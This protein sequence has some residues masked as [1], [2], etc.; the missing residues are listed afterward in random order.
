MKRNQLPRLTLTY[1][2]LIFL[3]IGCDAPVNEETE[4]LKAEN[5]KVEAN[6]EMYSQ[7]WDDILNKGQ[8]DLFNEA[9][10]TEEIVIHASPENIVG[11]DN[12][13]D[14]YANYVTGFSNIEFTINDVFGQGNK[15]VKHWTFKGKHTG[16]LFGIPATGNDVNFE[17][18]TLVRMANGKV[19]EE[20][21]FFDN[22]EFLQQLGLIPRE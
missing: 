18:V 11:I 15:I 1:G 21:D 13:K 3:A 2:A 4:K 9:S 10:F 7:L 6:I 20:Q 14:F 5:A 16:D 22:H 12:V 19:A 17:G 8:L